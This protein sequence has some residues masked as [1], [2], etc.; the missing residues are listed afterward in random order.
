MG[1]RAVHNRIG[2]GQ[3][4]LDLIEGGRGCE[5]FINSRMTSPTIKH[6]RVSSF[7]FIKILVTSITDKTPKT[8][9]GTTLI[10]NFFRN[11]FANIKCVKWSI[12]SNIGQ[13]T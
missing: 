1:G 3:V 11:L 2:G 9:G 12:F 10:A 6:R 5:N 8:F 7:T 4:F 13:N